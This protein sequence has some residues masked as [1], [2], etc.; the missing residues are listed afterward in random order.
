VVRQLIELG[1]DNRYLVGGDFFLETLYLHSHCGGDFH[2]LKDQL[3]KNR[4]PDLIVGGSALWDTGADS[5]MQHRN[6]VHRCGMEFP[7]LK[8]RYSNAKNDSI[9]MILYRRRLYNLFNFVCEHYGAGIFTWRTSGLGSRS[10]KGKV[11][12]DNVI[13][14]SETAPLNT[15]ARNVANEFG[16]PIEDYE[17]IHR[18]FNLSGVDKV[19]PITQVVEEGVQNW[20]E[21]ALSRG[22]NAKTLSQKQQDII[23]KVLD[24]SS[25]D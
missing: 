10:Y 3:V 6:E 22:K 18:K 19:H 21:G 11:V 9:V 5:N 4:K 20:L 23:T 14:Y 24:I 7:T 1:S 8:G 15:I 2:E 13:N 16:I 12:P 17:I 25:K